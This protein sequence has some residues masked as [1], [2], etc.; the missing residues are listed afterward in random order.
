MVSTATQELQEVTTG[1]PLVWEV[2]DPCP[3]TVSTSPGLARML[4]PMTLL[5]LLP[6]PH[7]STALSQTQQHTGDTFV[8][9]NPVVALQSNAALCETCASLP[10][11]LVKK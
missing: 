3:P 9:M 6:K 4:P 10:A 8:L 2:W 5:P 7:L 1:S 11:K